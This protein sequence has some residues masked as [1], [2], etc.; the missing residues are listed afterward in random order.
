MIRTMEAR[1]TMSV[2]FQVLDKEHI[3]S[4]AIWTS[5]AA[6]RRRPDANLV[7]GW[8]E[9]PRAQAPK[10]HASLYPVSHEG[11]GVTG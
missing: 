8:E 5:G 7:P 3:I 6:T 10:T 1:P 9:R 4:P 11:D 2:H